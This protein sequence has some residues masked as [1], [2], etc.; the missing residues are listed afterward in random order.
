M[1]MAALGSMIVGTLVVARA[2]V[3]EGS[4]DGALFIV[5]AA[6]FAGG[7]FAFVVIA[8][9]WLQLAATPG[10]A[11]HTVARVG[12]TA[13]AAA[14]PT[15]LAMRDLIWS[16]TGHKAEVQTAQQL[17]SI[18]VASAIICGVVASMVAYVVTST[19][20]RN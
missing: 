17:A 4:S 12:A 2:A 6:V 9:A 16:A 13:A 14:L 5:E 18:T 19:A 11:R 3:A 7:T 8:D 15:S 20:R 1:V 10:G